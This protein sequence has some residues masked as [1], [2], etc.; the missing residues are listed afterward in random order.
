M[1][2]ILIATAVLLAWGCA[3]TT[4]IPEPESKE[5]QV[6][7]ARCGSCHSL[8]HPKRS[9]YEHWEHLVSVMESQLEHRG[10]PPLT[11]EDRTAILAYLKTHS[12]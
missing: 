3:Q 5:A 9:G 12:R 11:E 4:P 8:P 6:Y 10:M 1:R 7:A 2:S